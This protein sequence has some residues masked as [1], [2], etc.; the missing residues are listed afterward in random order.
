MVAG[1]VIEEAAGSKI[2]DGDVI[3]TYARYISIFIALRLL[4][5]TSLHRSSVVEKVLLGAHSEGRQFSVVVV[6]SRPMLEGR[7]CPCYIKY[8]AHP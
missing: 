4:S 6:D 8:I 1:Q 5:L 2:R 3:L 7:H